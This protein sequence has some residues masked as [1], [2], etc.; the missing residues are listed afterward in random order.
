LINAAQQQIENLPAQ[1]FHNIASRF[2]IFFK[3]NFKNEEGNTEFRD[4]LLMVQEKNDKQY[5]VTARSG[6]LKRNFENEGF[7]HLKN[8][9]IYNN[10][11]RKQTDCIATF[12]L[13]EIAFEK[14]FFKNG[15][16]E[17]NR[18]VKFLS[19]EELRK[20][21]CSFREI[22][23]RIAQILW[24]LLL[25]FLIFWSMM[26]LGREKSNIL[27]S[28]ITSGGLF[29]FSYLSINMAYYLLNG[30]IITTII[31][32]GIPVTMTVGLYMIYQSRWS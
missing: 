16:Q 22:H 31:F 20:N 29:L 25:P 4:V 17:K 2:T 26:V 6:V 10:G 19:W 32:Y 28:L 23:K 14:L 8:G 5:L 7:L 12:K 18:Q 13:L 3:N 15:I 27:L 21:D 30:S 11:I 24:Q 1:Q 9:V